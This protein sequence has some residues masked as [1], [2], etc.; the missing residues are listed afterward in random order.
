MRKTLRGVAL[1]AVGMLCLAGSA[2]AATTEVVTESDVVR[3]AENTPPANDWVV[4]TRAGTPPT[5]AAFVPGPATPPLGVGSLQLTT[6]TSSHKVFAFNYDHI[7]T[8]L[9]DVDDISYSTYR[10]AGS[11]QQLTGLNLQIDPDGPEG[12]ATFSTLVFE[13]V[14]NTAQGAVVNNQWQSWQAD[15]SG[16]WWSTAALNGQCAGAG[17]ACQR[18]WNQIVAN[19]PAAT[20]VSGVGV[21][22]GSGNAG[23]VTSVDAFTFDETT[24]DFDVDSD[25]DGVADGSDNCVNTPNPNQTDTDGDGQGDACDADDDNDG[26]ADGPDNCETTPNADQS[27]NDNDGIGTACDPSELPGSK[28]ECKD[29]GWAN[30]YDENGTRFKNQGDCVSYVASQGKNK[31]AG[32]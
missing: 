31:P 22:Q 2:H 14:Y 19:N 10:S 29:G 13:P 21:N 12:P 9:A 17:A 16:R 8:A 4:Y 32:S 15:G 24:Y 28:D 3:Q 23:L 20:I 6:T 11:G 18:T 7:G 25:G 30:Y 26:V 27:D 5:A 1:T